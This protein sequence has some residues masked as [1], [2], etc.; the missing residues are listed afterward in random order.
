[1][2]ITKPIS[3]VLISDFNDGF[4]EVSDENGFVSLQNFNSKTKKFTCLELVMKRRIWLKF[5]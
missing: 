1:M 3:S 5:H 4:Q 2:K